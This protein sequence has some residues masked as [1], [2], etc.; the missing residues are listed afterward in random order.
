MAVLSTIG[1]QNYLDVGDEP[2]SERASRRKGAPAQPGLVL[3]AANPI[4]LNL[5]AL[6]NSVV[7]FLERGP[8]FEEFLDDHLS[9]K[10]LEKNKYSR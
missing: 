4:A 5:T 8:N 10:A 2:P 7:R 1:V 6:R 9:S 3:C